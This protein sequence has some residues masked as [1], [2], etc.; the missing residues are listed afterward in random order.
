M[1]LY[2]YRWLDNKDFEFYRHAKTRII[3]YFERIGGKG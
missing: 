2:I 3:G 1:D